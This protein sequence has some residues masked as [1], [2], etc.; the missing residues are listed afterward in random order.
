MPFSDGNKDKQIRGLVQLRMNVMGI[1]KKSC[2]HD[3][4]SEFS[5]S[6]MFDVKSILGSGVFIR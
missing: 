3:G 2:F 5:L 6:L 4:S 1:T